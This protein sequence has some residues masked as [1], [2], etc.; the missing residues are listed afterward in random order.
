MRGSFRKICVLSCLVIGFYAQK[1]ESS[2]RSSTELVGV[3]NDSLK[4]LFQNF[5]HPDI[6]FGIVIASPSKSYPDYFYHWTRDAALT[7]DSLYQ[8]YIATQDL[9][10]KEQILTQARAWIRAEIDIQ[11]KS[12]TAPAGI[13]EPKYYVSGYAY[14]YPWARPQDDGPATRSVSIMQWA[15]V[16]SSLGEGDYVR[17]TLFRPELPARSIIKRDL[18]YVAHNWRQASFDLWEEIK[19][20]HFFTRALQLKALRMGAVFANEWGDPEAAQFY[21]QE[22][23]SIAAEMGRFINHDRT[24]LL[25]TLDWAGG[26][27][28]KTSNLDIAIILAA[29]QAL[30][31][32]AFF[33]DNLDVF[34]STLNL[35]EQKFKDLY[36]INKNNPDMAAALGRYPEDVYT[37]ITTEGPANPWFIATHGAAEFYCK[38]AEAF[39]KSGNQEKSTEFLQK[40]LKYFERTLLHRNQETGEMSEQ[41]SRENGFLV[42]ASHL[43]WS[44][45]SYLT[46]YLACAQ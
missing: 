16:L 11:E 41:F 5:N 39:K 12:L 35:L 19:G 32:E 46:A 40:G 13:A 14:D 45:A 2:N 36:T 29:N 9:S 23:N 18:E 1:A 20:T 28:H 26:W 4:F 24:Y 27:N 15:Q 37:G 6:N 38:L 7:Q 30:F 44:Y 33:Q 10:H 17:N 22:A 8:V 31:Q 25:E 21:A 3:Y 34:M 42:G 43:T